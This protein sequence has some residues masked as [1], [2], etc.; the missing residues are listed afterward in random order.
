MTEIQLIIVS[1][2]VLLTVLSTVIGI[3]VSFI[4]R[5]LKKVIDR[6]DS[7]LSHL[8]GKINVQNLS[9]NRSLPSIDVPSPKVERHHSGKKLP[10]VSTAFG[11]RFFKRHVS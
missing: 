2:I 4:F 1:A 5:D 11:R 8:E 7:V 6:M 3:Q 10:K 9:H